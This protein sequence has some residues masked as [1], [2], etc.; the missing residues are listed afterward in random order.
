MT[1]SSKAVLLFCLLTAVSAALTDPDT[2]WQQRVHYRMNV[3]LDPDEHTLKGT[4]IISYTNLSPDTLRKIYMHLYP[5]AFL[6]GSVKHQEMK[7]YGVAAR[8]FLRSFPEDSTSYIAVDSFEVTTSGGVHSDRL[9]VED[10]I[11]EAPLPGPLFPGD[12]MKLSIEWRHVVRGFYGR[13]GYR[14][15]QYDFAQWYPKM[16]VYD[17][18]GWHNEPFHAIGEFYGEFGTYDVTIDVPARFV[19]GGTGVVVGGD[20][21]WQ[22]VSVD[23]S[24]DFEE[25]LSHVD[26]V[27]A[28]SS[29]RRVV[30]FHAEQVHDFAWITSPEFVYEGGEWENIDIHVLYDRSAAEYWS[31]AVV[32]RTRRV[33]DWLTN[34][35]GEYPYPQVTVT[36][37]LQRGGMEYPMLVMNGS[38]SEYLIAHEVG[39][40]WFY[41]ILANNE[42]DE[43]W[44]DEGFTSFQTA[45]HMANRFPGGRDL[46]NRRY[47]D[48]QRSR[49]WF[50]S[51]QDG[52]EWSVIRFLTSPH[53]EPIATKSHL[54][55]GR[56]EYGMNAY[57][58][59]QLMLASLRGF[60]GGEVFD[61]GLRKYY[62]RWKLKHTDE[63]RFRESMEEVS[64]RSL[65]SFF[66]Q[67]LHEAGFVDYTVSG[68]SYSALGDGRYDVTVGIENLGTMNSPLDLKLMLEGGDD[69]TL[70]TEVHLSDPGGVISL[71]VPGRPD[72]V[73]IDPDNWTMDVD[74][75]NNTTA[76]LP[77]E[78]IFNWPGMSYFPRKLYVV[79]WNPVLWYSDGDGLKPGVSFRRSYGP[80]HRFDFFLTTG[81][82]SDKVYSEV[83]FSE[84]LK[85]LIPWLTINANVFTLEGLNGG[86]VDA[87]YEWSRYFRMPPT[88]S[89][90]GGFYINSGDGS[91][92]TDLYEAGRTF[93]FYGKYGL[94]LEYGGQGGGVALE[95]ALAPGGLSDWDFGRVVAQASFGL[96]KDKFRAAAGIYAGLMWSG[97]AGIP[98]QEKFNINSAGSSDYFSRPYLRTASS[99]YGVNLMDIPLRNRF[100]ISGEGNV[101]GYFNHGF[102]G[103]E[104]TVASTLEMSRAVETEALDLRL[105]AFVDGGLFWSDVDRLAGNFLADAGVGVVLSKKIIGHRWNLRIDFPFWL[106][107]TESPSGRTISP[108]DM[109]RFV[110]AF[111]AGL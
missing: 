96:E 87:S 98:G 73:L 53:N 38:D 2:Y 14:G 106:N 24:A 83:R 78:F 105:R 101:R 100:H 32:Q 40:I 57:D 45:W 59:P 37:A 75:R 7:N 18:K 44:L 86:G 93:V 69:V 104:K 107:F 21:G 71:T 95:M 88:H 19:V 111:D 48:F 43:P 97:E 80:W 89:L 11:L 102:S 1:G 109:N 39:H 63:Q 3:S 50:T 6:H 17:E 26:S 30:T 68:I 29:A 99:F 33:L 79:K 67:W 77:D 82:A 84:T 58:K 103:A 61:E 35:F 110:V 12:S 64:G 13:A 20:P 49:W 51:M 8:F 85:S 76:S 46:E 15:E 108:F 62:D 28:N 91:V 25:W 66:Q 55:S 42:V 52:D 56:G 72:E 27:E 23:T 94:D 65:D 10:T 47:D 74:L 16:V 54:A 81:L 70:R 34:Q 9:R 31:K 60:L 4:S 92:L 90:S 41:G 5:N 36:H 22:R